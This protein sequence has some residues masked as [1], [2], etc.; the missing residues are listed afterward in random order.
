MSEAIETQESIHPDGW[1]ILGQAKHIPRRD[2]PASIATAPVSDTFKDSVGV[3]IQ[4]P[5]KPRPTGGRKKRKTMYKCAMCKEPYWPTTGGGQRYCS[6][7]CK[8]IAVAIQRIARWGYRVCPT[9]HKAFVPKQKK[10][11]YCSQSCGSSKPKG[12]KHVS[13]DVPVL[14]CDQD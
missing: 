2:W 3:V 12:D 10:A 8:G 1:G 9:C 7:E 11:V 6:D 14:P 4:A 5:K 13:K